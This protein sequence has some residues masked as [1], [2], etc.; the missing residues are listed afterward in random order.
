MKQVDEVLKVCNFKRLWFYRG[1]Y[2]KNEE[3]VG[4]WFSSDCHVVLGLVFAL[5][6]YRFSIWIARGDYEFER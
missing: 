6:K 3:R 5:W 2:L 4:F 1:R